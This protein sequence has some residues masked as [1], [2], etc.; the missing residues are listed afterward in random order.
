[1]SIDKVIE[2]L[3]K[4]NS[5]KAKKKLNR[6]TNCQEAIEGP[7]TFPINLPAVET[8][9]EIAIRNN[10]RSRQIGQVSRRCRDCLKTVFKEGKN[11]DMNAI[12]HVTQP[13]IQT[14]S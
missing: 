12:K 13:K 5:M 7:G 1:M 3:S 10:L 11:I 4:D 14:T 9:I 6:S 2:G 8:A